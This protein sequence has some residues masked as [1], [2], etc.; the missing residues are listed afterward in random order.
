M[1]SLKEMRRDFEKMQVRHLMEDEWIEKYPGLTY[2]EKIN[3]AD[4]ILAKQSFGHIDDAKIIKIFKDQIRSQKKVVQSQKKAF[5]QKKQSKLNAETAMRQARQDV[6]KL[7]SQTSS[8]I[9]KA[10]VVTSSGES[11][12]SIPVARVLRGPTKIPKT[13]NEKS[14]GCFGRFCKR[15]DA[16]EGGRKRKT[17]RKRKHKKRKTKKGKRK[18]KRKTR[19]RKKRTKRKTRKKRR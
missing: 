11:K 5:Q 8:K 4:S 7:M 12:E 3:L 10:P 18:R 13:E 2:D 17:R 16:T 19:R 14:P 1:A 15:D 6:A 9:V